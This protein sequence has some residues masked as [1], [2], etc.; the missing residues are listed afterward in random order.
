MNLRFSIFLTLFVSLNSCSM[1]TIIGN[2]NSSKGGG[3]GSGQTQNKNEVSND[4]TE[5]GYSDE[6]YMDGGM[7]NDSD[8]TPVPVD[9]IVLLFTN[10]TSPVAFVDT[11]EY[12]AELP[13]KT[14]YTSQLKFEKN[15]NQVQLKING[16]TFAEA[17][18]TDQVDGKLD[19][20]L[21]VEKTPESYACGDLVKSEQQIKINDS[22]FD[23]YEIQMTG[24]NKKVWQLKWY[25][26][27]SMEIEQI[28]IFEKIDDDFQYILK[29]SIKT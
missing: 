28:K 21:H 22:L 14:I 19:S 1:G 3:K 20:I 23:S 10:C 18:I 29:M 2:G 8:P 12:I 24:E 16:S 7:V 4:T 17:T 6:P 27:E 26:S 9:Q 5:Q 13:G 11:V 25:E 15:G